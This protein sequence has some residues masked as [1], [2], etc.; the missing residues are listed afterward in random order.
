MLNET[1]QIRSLFSSIQFYAFSLDFEDQ[2]PK[3]VKKMS[4]IYL[5]SKIGTHRR[6]N[7][8]R[9]IYLTV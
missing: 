8:C 3:S 1:Y 4:F 5:R 6:Q 2:R 9:K 7:I